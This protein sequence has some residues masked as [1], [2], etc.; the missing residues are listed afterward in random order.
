M[1]WCTNA[2]TLPEAP[3]GVFTFYG[4]KSDGEAQYLDF[5]APADAR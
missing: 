1:G 2:R 4:K 3:K 5:T